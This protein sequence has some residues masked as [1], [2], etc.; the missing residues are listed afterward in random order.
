MFEDSPNADQKEADKFSVIDV[1]KK[2][3]TPEIVNDLGGSETSKINE[4]VAKNEVHES[5]LLDI[6]IDSET[7]NY[8]FMDVTDLSQDI[9][10]TALVETRHSTSINHKSGILI[11]VDKELSINDVTR[12]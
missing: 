11:I 5:Q 7:A 10:K 8:D 1:P 9:N 2:E 3:E 4:G 6:Q 12:N